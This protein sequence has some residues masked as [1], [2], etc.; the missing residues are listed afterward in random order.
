[1]KIIL[2]TSQI[3]YIKDNYLNLLG[4]FFK[5]N[6]KQ[7]AGLIILKNFS[8]DLMLKALALRFTG[9][10]NMSKTLIKNMTQLHLKK[11]EKLCAEYGIPVRSFLSM[12]E[13]R[14]INWV[15]E[16]DVDLIV[17]M[18]TRCIYK[19]EILQAPRLGCINIHHGI[20]PESRG[21]FCDLHA[22]SS[23]NPAGFSIHYM[24][25]KIDAGQILH[26]EIVSDGSKKDYMNYLANSGPI[27]ARALSKVINDIE[28]SGLLGFPNKTDHPVFTKNPTR[29]EIKKMLSEGMIL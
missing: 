21:T 5:S 16:L 11:R 17:N 8:I 12:N 15:K 28:K 24:T 18:R 13:S 25:E 10:P 29:N 27:E 9:A 20:L 14:A 22:L 3:T 4:P 2:V 7:I 19:K 23:G 6:Y 26:V 1:M